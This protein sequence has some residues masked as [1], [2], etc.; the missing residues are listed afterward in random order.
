MAIP[1]GP[2]NFT[3]A[4]PYS[5]GDVLAG[6][7]RLLADLVSQGQTW[8]AGFRGPSITIF[9]RCAAY[10]EPVTLT[11]TLQSNS[12]PIGSITATMVQDGAI[13][14]L[15]VPLVFS[16]EDIVTLYI[17]ARTLIG[18]NV[19]NVLTL[20]D[21]QFGAEVFWTNEVLCLES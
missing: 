11:A 4:R 15:L 19:P 3:F 6:T 13:H 2:Q 16:D 17:D 1:T 12:R 20:H 5:A 21:I 10:T 14:S 18:V 8:Q 9:Y 7:G